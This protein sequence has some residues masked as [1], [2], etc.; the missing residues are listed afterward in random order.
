MFRVGAADTVTCSSHGKYTDNILLVRVCTCKVEIPFRLLEI[1]GP[2][3][4]H[5]VCRMRAVERRLQPHLRTRSSGFG[6]GVIAP[7]WLVTSISAEG[8]D[9]VYGR[10]L[11]LLRR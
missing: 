11:F 10:A 7:T 4:V 1:L 9:S 6:R 3:Y 8:K 2:S 5:T